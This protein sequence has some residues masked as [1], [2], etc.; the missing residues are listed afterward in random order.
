M[1]PHRQHCKLRT[2]VYATVTSGHFAD[3]A[4][5]WPRPAPHSWLGGF[6]R[7]RCAVWVTIPAVDGAASPKN[8]EKNGAADE[9]W[10]LAS[11]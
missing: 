3:P 2:H 9:R 7:R 10:Q 5:I 8:A 1:T 11:S 4:L 6:R